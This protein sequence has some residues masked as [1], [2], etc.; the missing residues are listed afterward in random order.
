MVRKCSL[1]IFLRESN[2]ISTPDE[3]WSLYTQGKHDDA[4]HEATN[5]LAQEGLDEATRQALLGVQAWCYYHRKD[6]P[7]AMNSIQQ[8]GSDPRARRCLMYLYAFAPPYRDK[9]ALDAMLPGIRCRRHDD[10]R[11]GNGGAR[12]AGHTDA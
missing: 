11:F 7:T 12:S 4:L 5:A 9:A 6:F 3:L 2:R 8:A 1:A 10:E